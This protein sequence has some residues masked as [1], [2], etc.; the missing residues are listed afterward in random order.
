MAELDRA[1][2]REWPPNQDFGKDWRSDVK[3]LAASWD[4]L[5]PRQRFLV[6]QQV[7]SVLRTVLVNDVESR[8]R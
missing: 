7:A 2:V 5:S 6:L 4:D 1:D 8:L 3:K